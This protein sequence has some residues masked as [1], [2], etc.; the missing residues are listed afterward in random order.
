MLS[1]WCIGE[2]KRRI[3]HHHRKCYG[4]ALL[5]ID[6]SSGS[7]DGRDPRKS[8]QLEERKKDWGSRDDIIIKSGSGSGACFTYEAI[9]S[10]PKS[11]CS[12]VDKARSICNTNIWETEERGTLNYHEFKSNLNYRL[13][14]FISKS[15]LLSRDSTK[16]VK[17]Q[18]RTRNDEPGL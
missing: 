18:G 17:G 13:R 6:G 16:Q 11:S 4:T 5:W 2:H 7:S 1:S 9:P 15:K 10:A 14:P 3:P 8:M 12:A